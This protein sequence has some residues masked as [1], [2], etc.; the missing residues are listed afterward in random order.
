M[1]NHEL[2][3]MKS[4]MRDEYIKKHGDP[5]FFTV[6]AIKWVNMEEFTKIY[7]PKGQVLMK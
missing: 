2:I 7:P 4:R 6:S 1:T 3:E 5:E